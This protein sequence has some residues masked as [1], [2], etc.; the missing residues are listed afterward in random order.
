MMSPVYPLATCL[1]TLSASYTDSEV[2]PV[3]LTGSG[4]ST[5]PPFG[6]ALQP[7]LK[8][9]SGGRSRY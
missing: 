5:Q 9:R 4:E 7:A 8:G 6:A 3:L 2:V 1:L